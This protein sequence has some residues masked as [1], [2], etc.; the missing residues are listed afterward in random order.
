[1]VFRYL[2]VGGT[3]ST[4]YSSS[5]PF[6]S[7][8]FV[9]NG[10]PTVT[11]ITVTHSRAHNDQI[12]VRLETTSNVTIEY[13][14]L[15][16]NWNKEVIRGSGNVDSTTI[17]YNY[18]LNGCQIN[19]D[20]SS[21]A[22]CTAEI[23]LWDGGSYQNNKIYG[24]ILR[25]T[26][27]IGHSNGCIFNGGDGTSNLIGATA[28]NG[29]IANNTIIGVLGS[30]CDVQSLGT[31]NQVVNNI[32]YGVGGS[33]STSCLSNTCANNQKFTVDPFVSSGTGNVHLVAPTA[34]GTTLAAPYNADLDGQTRGQS[35]TWDL[36]AFE[37][38]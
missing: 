7:F 14:C 25:D 1:L 2:D 19:P 4:T 34:N 37:K 13:N 23:A 21:T 28:V 35:G 38:P 9:G 16:P 18:I 17:R 12:P 20:D 33:T 5:I 15:G 24:N 29:L 10:S 30:D 22:G 3:D 8:Y 11:D 32:W 31:N 26:I 6:D 27:N 36:G